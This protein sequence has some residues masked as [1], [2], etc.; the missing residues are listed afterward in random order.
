MARKKQKKIARRKTEAEIA[1]DKIRR[2]YPNCV[3]SY[4]ECPKAIED[5]YKPPEE[6]LT[7]PVYAEWR[8]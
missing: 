5:K 6:C 3:G 2:S 1:W 7:C 8:R 4:P